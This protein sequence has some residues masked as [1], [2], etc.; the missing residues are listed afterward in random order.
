MHLT[1]EKK[2]IFTLIALTILMLLAVM[3]LP[4]SASFTNVGV[5]HVP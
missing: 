5:D 2:V 1:S 4:I 3:F